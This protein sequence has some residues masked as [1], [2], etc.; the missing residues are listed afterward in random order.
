M[1]YFV[2]GTDTDVGKTLVSCALLHAYA[3]QGAAV[4]GMKPVAAGVDASGVHE[5]VKLLN[6]ASN[7]SADAELINPYGFTAAIAPHL[8]AQQEN[9]RI[10]LSRIVTSFH[11]LQAVAEMVIVEGAGGFIVPLNEVED[12]S[13]LALR[14]GLPVVLVVGMRLGC[15]N[16]ALLTVQA[17]QARG[18][19]LAGWVANCVDE[20]MVMREQNI[21][22]LQQRIRAPLLAIVPYCAAPDSRMIPLQLPDDMMRGAQ[23]RAGIE[24]R[25]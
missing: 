19:K 5:D 11:A 12:S 1:S 6:A 4:I 2:T 3:A 8:A 18:L 10:D 23:L 21:V 22:A 16:H 20:Q 14:L 25:R 17:I 24:G 7:V 9:V 15:L 13:D